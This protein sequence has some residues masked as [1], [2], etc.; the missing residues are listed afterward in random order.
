MQYTANPAKADELIRAVQARTEAEDAREP[1]LHA[2]DLIYCLRK[3]WYRRNGH[4]EAERDTDG[5]LTLL[6]GKG[7]HTLLEGGRPEDHEILDTAAGPVHGTIDMVEYEDGLPI[8]VE[9]KSTRARATKPPIDSPHYLEQ[10]ATYC[11]MKAVTHGRLIIVH[12][13][14]PTIKCWDVEF[15]K[16]ELDQWAEEL[17]NRAL[18]VSDSELHAEPFD[19]Y[20]WECRYCSFHNNPCPGGDGRK[21]GWF[22]PDQLLLRERA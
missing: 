19:H 3:A 17:E 13:T 15:S 22:S 12:L 14:E 2:S 16:F 8:P 10:L 1:G 6:I 9:L 7:F 21:L 18:L 5:N 20:A 4:V 11:V